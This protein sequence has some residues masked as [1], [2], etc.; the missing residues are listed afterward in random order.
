MEEVYLDGINNP[1]PICCM[2]FESIANYVQW[3]QDQGA[4]E[5]MLRRYRR[6]TSCLYQWLPADKNL[7]RER[8]LSWRQSLKDDGYST[9]TELNYIKGINRYLD[10][11]GYSH[12]RFNQ[13]KPKD[14][15]GQTFGYLTAIE[16]TGDKNRRDIVWRCLCKCGNTYECI[17]S[18]LLAGNTLS[19]GCLRNENLKDANMFFAGTSLRQSL[20]DRVKSSCSESGFVGVS[21]KNDKWK[22]YICYKGERYSLGVYSKLEDAVKARAMGKEMVKSDAVALLETYEKLHKD[23]PERPS[24]ARFYYTKNQVPATKLRKNNTT[25]ATGVYRRGNRWLAKLGYKN[26]RYYLGSF[27]D[28]KSA[29]SARKEAE[30]ISM[31]NP[32]QFQLKYAE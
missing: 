22:A 23:A 19:C 15:A 29:I 18:R 16:P 28:I 6:F 32:Q 4:S 7:S 11:A 9:A 27:G 30:R 14:I 17:T 10:F 20:N 26:N 31:E 5:N 12:L 13:G 8:L 25:G 3:E 1:R 24:R 2:T 21:R